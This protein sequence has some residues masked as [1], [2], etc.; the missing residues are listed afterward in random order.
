MTKI[1]KNYFLYV[2]SLTM[3]F[4][5]IAYAQLNHFTPVAQTGTS[6]AV[7][8]Q[9]ATIND[10]PIVAGDE[11]A[12]FDDILCVGAA[13]FAGTYPL[14]IP[15]WIEYTPPGQDK[16]P[17]AK[18]GNSMIFK[19]WQQSSDIEVEGSPTYL[20]GS[21]FCE[22]LTV[23]SL[24][25][26]EILH[27][28]LSISDETGE[29]NVGVM[30][31]TVTLASPS[32]DEVK[33]D[34]QTYDETAVAPGDYTATSGVLIFPAGITTGTIFVPIIDD[35]QE[36]GDETFKVVLNNPVN[37]TITDNEGIGTITDDETSVVKLHE[38]TNILNYELS[39]NYPNPFN[40]ETTI[41]FQLGEDSEI[42]LTIYNMEGKI[43]RRLFSG[44]HRAGNYNIS[45][46]GR[47]EKSHPVTSGVYLYRLNA[48]KF[49][50]MKKMLYIK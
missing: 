37:A 4:C 50:A 12:V 23:V 36:E 38:K 11:I 15:S 8:I 21:K 2:L 19:I 42:N 41:H 40:P 33:V 30:G 46:D 24:L 17:G 10:T 1:R 25:D 18:C 26:A 6:D 3:L 9:S 39:Q 29:E 16:L 13:A 7:V 44:H 48:G 47:D 27:V 49:S 34:Y 45:W 22:P 28:T 20:T 14:T 43:I 32:V 5:N 35:T 31:F